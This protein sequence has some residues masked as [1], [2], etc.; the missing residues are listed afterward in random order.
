MDWAIR[1]LSATIT[2]I[3]GNTIVVDT[4][5]GLSAEVG[6]GENTNITIIKELGVADLSEGTNVVG[7]VQR[8]E[9]ARIYVQDMTIIPEGVGRGFGGSFG[10]AIGGGAAGTTNLSSVQGT[11]IEVEGDMV[12]VETTQGTLR[13]TVNDESSIVQNIPGALSDLHAEMGVIAFIPEGG[14]AANVV[15]GPASFIENTDGRLPG[16]RR[17]QGQ[18]RQNAPQ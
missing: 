15:A 4:E 11:V 9:D 18:R 6:I 12:H 5:D 2:E 13:L 17:G 10:G 1:Q 3:Q 8:G 14:T 7:V 16:V